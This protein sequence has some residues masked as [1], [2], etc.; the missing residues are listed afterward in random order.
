VNSLGVITTQPTFAPV[1]TVLEGRIV[2][3]GV[4]A[5]W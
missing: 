1:S 3:L 5:D 4:R 2:Q